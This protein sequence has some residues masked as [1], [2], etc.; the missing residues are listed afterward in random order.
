LSRA[1]PESHP[2]SRPPEN[3]RRRRAAGR[4]LIAVSSASIALRRR[5]ASVTPRLIDATPRCCPSG[6]LSWQIGN[7]HDRERP[8][9]RSAG[10][11]KTGTNPG[12]TRHLFDYYHQRRGGSSGI[13]WVRRGGPGR[14]DG[15]T[16]RPR[17]CEHL[18]VGREAGSGMGML[19][20]QRLRRETSPRRSAEAHAKP[21]V[22]AL[23]RAEAMA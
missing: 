2:H 22:E 11:Q 6:A 8:S 23:S 13:V 20:T 1:T 19:S 17:R 3:A 5:L 14:R 16:P 12:E 9:R 7:G 21:S 15:P 4:A 18:P 10:L